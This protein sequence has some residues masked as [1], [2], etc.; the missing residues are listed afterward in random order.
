MIYLAVTVLSAAVLAYEV[1]LMRLLA[2][3]Q[4]HH[5]AYMVIRAC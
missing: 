4:W 3:V 1:L 2:I 5:F